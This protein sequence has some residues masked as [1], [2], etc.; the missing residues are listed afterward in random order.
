MKKNLLA[1]WPKVVDLET[2]GSKLLDT[3]NPNPFWKDVFKANNELWDK[4]EIS[5]SKEVLAEPLFFNNKF[6]IG[7]NCFY[8][9]EWSENQVLAVKDLVKEDGNFLSLEDFNQLYN[10]NVQ[11]LEYYGCLSSIR[12]YLKKQGITIESKE[13]QSQAKVHQ[14]FIQAPKGSKIFYQILLSKAETS[15]A[16][17]NWELLLE[18]KVN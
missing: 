15:T 5:N 11:F 10:L 13:S 14:T 9:N 8:F 4:V 7:G 1:Q 3:S 16:C 18:R 6:K 2:Y 12:Q 17:T